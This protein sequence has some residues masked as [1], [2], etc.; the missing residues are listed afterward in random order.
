[1]LQ[2]VLVTADG[3]D[4]QLQYL[5]EG[6]AMLRTIDD[7]AKVVM[8]GGEWQSLMTELTNSSS[9]LMRVLSLVGELGVRGDLPELGI[10]LRKLLAKA[11]HRES[12]QRQHLMPRFYKNVRRAAS[13]RSRLWIDDSVAVP[14]LAELADREDLP[15]S[16][17]L[18]EGNP[19]RVEEI[20][21]SV[22]SL[23]QELGFEMIPE[24]DPA[25]GSWWQ[26]FKAKATRGETKDAV[27][28][29][30]L[31]LERA[32]EVKLLALPESE[33]NEHN[34]NA[35]ASL[36]TSLKSEPAAIIQ[37]GSVLLVKTPNG[38]NGE[39]AVFG[40]TL[41]LYELRALERHPELLGDPIGILSQLP[42]AAR[43]LEVSDDT[44]PPALDTSGTGTN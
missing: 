36:L 8:C 35:L 1:M 37:I 3:V 43:S 28:E 20:K 2:E 17:Y 44:V 12:G 24:S 25:V 39:G 10:L 27:V 22:G 11:S 29:R 33:A 16:I 13:D 31:K 26:R 32:A 15:V 9:H 14:A 5:L 6:L 19:V 40:K 41:T 18:S 30:L 34:A 7:T 23:L 38:P 42:I 4:Q 21:T